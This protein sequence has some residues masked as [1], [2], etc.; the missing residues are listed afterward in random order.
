M[1]VGVN[2]SLD[3]ITVIIRFSSSDIVEFNQNNDF[4]IDQI[5]SNTA[6]KELICRFQKLSETK[7]K[8]IIPAFEG[9][10]EVIATWYNIADTY[11]ATVSGKK[12]TIFRN[13][14]N[15]PSQDNCITETCIIKI[16]DINEGG[17][18]NRA[19]DEFEELYKNVCLQKVVSNINIQRQ[20]EIW[21]KWIEAQHAIIKQLQE[22]FEIIGRPQVKTTIQ[23]FK[24]KNGDPLIAYEVSVMIKETITSEYS[25]LESSLKE[26]GILTSTDKSGL[27]RNELFEPDGTIMLT[28]EEIE[29]VL[30]PLIKAQYSQ[31]FEREHEISAILKI[32]NRLDFEINS[33][34]K[35]IGWNLKAAI[36]NESNLL[37]LFSPNS[38]EIRIPKELK[39]KYALERKG[40]IATIRTR[41]VNGQ[42]EFET[43]NTT[44]RDGVYGLALE[45]QKAKLESEVIAKCE[46]Y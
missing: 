20:Q 13:S 33:Y 30:D 19:S 18:V 3:P 41:D 45:R 5:R 27:H 12:E 32:R 44:T 8:I 23:P 22:P 9:Q 39:E 21:F 37:I 17:R 25:P 16:I 31:I 42:L 11:L 15:H 26:Y 24:D 7:H 29:K 1:H 40:L 36:D 2:Y 38:K 4:A 28:A 34:F 6:N 14:I 46:L 10:F 43:I 35:S